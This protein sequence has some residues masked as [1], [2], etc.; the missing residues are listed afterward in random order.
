MPGAGSPKGARR[1]SQTALSYF[2]AI[3]RA[4]ELSPGDAYP[5]PVVD[6]DAGRARALEA[7]SGRDF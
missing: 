6:L 4:W 5:E 7:Y 2:D 1:P 3:P